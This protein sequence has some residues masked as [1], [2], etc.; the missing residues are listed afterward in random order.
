MK[1]LP[2]LLLASSVLLDPT[3]VSAAMPC[4][5]SLEDS[6]AVGISDEV[7]LLLSV[8]SWYCWMLMK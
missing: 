2:P 1:N 4:D 6:V 8:S 5:Y 3:L 7:D